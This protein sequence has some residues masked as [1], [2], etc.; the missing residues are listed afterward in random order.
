MTQ[1]GCTR[2]NCYRFLLNLLVG[3]FLFATSVLSS[4]VSL[5]S[6]FA[7]RFLTHVLIGDEGYMSR[8]LVI[9]VKFS[10]LQVEQ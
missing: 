3:V 1:R 5:R 7:V 10:Y 6:V 9:L 4:P 8:A 2:C